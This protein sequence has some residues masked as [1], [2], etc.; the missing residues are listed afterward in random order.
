[1]ER[2]KLLLVAAPSSLITA[3][4]CLNNRSNQPRSNDST[5]NKQEQ[6]DKNADDFQAAVFVIQAV[7][8]VPDDATIVSIDE[9][10]MFETD[11]VEN[12]MSIASKNREEIIEEQYDEDQNQ[13]YWIGDVHVERIEN[14]SKYNSIKEK[15][16]DLPRNDNSENMPKG[17]YV[18]YD[19]EVYVINL[20]EEH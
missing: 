13:D 17:V 7:I 11:L 9:S 18:R 2:R 1:M 3:I 5:E 6:T 14:V 15:Y 10:E 16:D 8:P 12:A 4:G 19:D 20:V